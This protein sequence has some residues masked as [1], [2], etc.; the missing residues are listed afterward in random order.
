MWYACLL[1]A[2]AQDASKSVAGPVTLHVD[3]I[4]SPAGAASR[5]PRFTVD[6]TGVVHLSWLDTEDS[7]AVL[8]YARLDGSTWSAAREIA[9]GDRWFVNW[10]DFPSLAVIDDEHRLAHFLQKSSAGTY[11]YDVHVTRSG[12]G[13]A[14][15]STPARLHTHT[16]AGEHGFV[17]LAPS[18]GSTAT[19]VW[20][21]GRNTK[22]HGEGAGEMALYAR[23]IEGDGR[24][25][26]EIVIDPRVCD[27]CPTSAVRLAD[28]ALLVAYRDR[29]SDEVR[30]ISVVRIVDG[31]VA[32]A[33]WSSGDGWKVAGCPVN[34]PVL[35][36]RG[37]NVALTW[38]TFGSDM[39]ARVSCAFS[40]DGGRSFGP[41]VRVANTRAHGRVDATFD[42]SNR[43]LVTWLEAD[44]G[45][46]EWRVARIDV[47]GRVIDERRVVETTTTRESGLARLAVG[48]SGVFFVWTRTEPVPRVAVSRL[49]WE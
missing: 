31:V 1:V 12:D 7:A 30:D 17:S 5:C 14:T 49:R 6:A 46:A 40:K 27:C 44:L 21:D 10:A 11:D 34:G 2:V 3:E 20:L 24:L 18:S 13:G 19:A 28:G 25:G 33:S 41:P 48:K 8:R 36:V 39:R 37:E 47:A 16:G 23:S 35:A 32:E 42:E 15:W 4:V 29:S 38:F 26:K 43:L 45:A 9:R 22:A